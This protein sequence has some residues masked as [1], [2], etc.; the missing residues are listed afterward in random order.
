MSGRFTILRSSAGAGKTH[1]LV[2][3]Y[4]RLCLGAPDP[5][6]YRRILALTFTNKAAREMKERV[7]HVLEALAEGREDDG[8]VNNIRDEIQQQSSLTADVLIMK[9]KVVHHHMLHHWSDLSITTIDAFMRRLVRPFARDLQLD[10]D[11]RMTTA[12]ADYR[13]RAVNELL[14]QAGTP[15]APTELLMRI[16]EALVEDEAAW[17]VQ[18]PL[19]EL[20]KELDRERAVAPLR[21]YQG[22]PPT[23]FL[24]TERQLKGNEEHFTQRVRAL[25]ERALRVLTSVEVG[26]EDLYQGGRGPYSTFQ[27]LARFEGKWPPTNHLA[28]CLERGDWSAGKAHASAKSSLAGI[29]TSLDELGREVMR[30]QADEL[31]VYLVERAIR[32][33]LLPA[34]ALHLVH[35]RLETI[36]QRDGVHFFSDLTRRVVELVHEDPAPFIYEQIGQRYRHFL[37]DEFQD[38]SLAQWHA[39]LPL[40]ENALSVG[41]EVLLVGDAKQAIYRWR[42]GDVEQFIA[43]PGLHQAGHLPRGHELEAQLRASA[44]IAAPL[45]D[46]RRSGRS[47]IATNN[48]L[49]NTLALT[50]PERLQPVYAASAQEAFRERDGYVQF[51]IVAPRSQD[52]ENEG[53]DELKPELE[54]L[55]AWI[56][57]CIQDGY[58]WPDMAVLVYT[59]NQATAVTHALHAIHVPTRSRDGQRLENDTAAKAVID[60]LR[61]I[62]RPDVVMAMRVL[63]HRACLADPADGQVDPLT[64]QDLD[65]RPNAIL[66][67]LLNEH[68][69]IPTTGPLSDLV[70]WCGHWFGLHAATCPGLLTLLDDVVTFQSQGSAGLGDLLLHWESTG[71]KRMVQGRGS[72]DAVQVMTIHTSKGL[73][74]PV[75][76]VPW[77]R[78]STSGKHQERLWVAADERVPGLSSTLVK[79]SKELEDLVP[80]VKHELELR[81]LDE[82]DL[83]YVAFTRPEERLYASV[84]NSKSAAGIQGGLLKYIRT[85]GSDAG[86]TAGTALPASANTTASHLPTFL[87]GSKA[88]PA[89]PHIRITAPVEWD[90]ASPDPYRRNGTVL[91]AILARM[92]HPDE[93]PSLIEAA[94]QSG[95]LSM[96][97]APDLL[98]KLLQAFS[99]PAVA[100]LFSGNA[101][102]WKE[103]TLIADTTSFPRPDRVEEDDRGILVLDY[104]FGK[105]RPEHHEQVSGYVDLLKGIHPEKEV[106]GMLL[107]LPEG[108]I[109][110]VS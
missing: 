62:H 60:L 48:A 31:P 19:L 51:D 79:P 94:C 67:R 70:D 38:T 73:Q 12:Q 11:L 37:I 86:M 76:M 8:G 96:T 83:L 97:D 55:Q 84:R 47:I 57:T 107:Y 65:M 43:L 90:P 3:T 80:E 24:T 110:Q 33:D 63:Q 10:Q 42:D 58:A 1:A 88:G 59:G 103:V 30:V 32:R 87:N 74:F 64:D 98:N 17:A 22:I 66:D 39:L 15:E 109:V 2:R 4:L 28:K 49:F 95:Q 54:R 53:T 82:L 71:K 25:G 5:D 68:R 50:L 101:R 7:L 9:A 26:P 92:A 78:R 106:R 21:D 91:H 18:K 16:G 105:P 14:A 6:A 108:A 23:E 69:T 61:Y 99:Q 75:V 102:A 27:Q 81:Q 46:N 29:S 104:K 13:A 72:A 40:V 89:L 45:V 100:A 34:A 35:D 56:K 93:L 36:K 44:I 77:T 85:L 20:A 52:E 41:G